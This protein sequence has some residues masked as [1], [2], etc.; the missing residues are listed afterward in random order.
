MIGI[1]L[2]GL[3]TFRSGQFAKLGVGLFILGGI[4]FNLPP[5]P[6]L[7]LILVAGGVI[8]GVGALWLGWTLW[9]GEAKT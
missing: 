6:A 5:A 4:L 2:L 9:S 1:I 7:H 8:Y 3:A